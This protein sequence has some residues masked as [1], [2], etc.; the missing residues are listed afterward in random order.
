MK[1]ILFNEVSLDGKYAYPELNY[2]L[3]YGTASE[4]KCQ[5]VMFGSKTARLAMPKPSVEVPGDLTKH[6]SRAR[7]HKLPYLVIPDSRG[8][9]HGRLHDYRRMPYGRDVIAL[10][11]RST[12]VRYIEYLKTRDYDHITAGNDKV[13]LAKAFKTL[14]QKYGIKSIRSDGGGKL[15]AVL[16]KQNLVDEIYLLVSPYLIGTGA[17]LFN[18][19]KYSKTLLLKG[20]KKTGKGYCFIHYSIKRK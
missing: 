20:M 10:V 13:D 11:S 2:D 16:L 17:G 4:I 15:Q 14:E 7:D 3:Y 12:P 6:A 1:V 5:A 18:K 9:L 19:I 8:V